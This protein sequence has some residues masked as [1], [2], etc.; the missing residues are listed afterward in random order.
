MPCI[1]DLLNE[2]LPSN[3]KSYIWALAHLTFL[4]VDL[5]LTHHS[6]PSCSTSEVRT[7]KRRCRRGDLE[8]LDRGGLLREALKV[9]WR[10][11][12]EVTNEEGYSYSTTFLHRYACVWLYVCVFVCMYVCVF[13]CMYVCLYK[14][15]FHVGQKKSHLVL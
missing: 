6:L 7:V 11:M 12:E 8:T 1:S 15:K 10:R 4:S 5:Y 14:K 3:W 9:F 2:G 13:V